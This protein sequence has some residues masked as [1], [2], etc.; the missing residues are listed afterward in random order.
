MEDI[1]M[2]GILRTAGTLWIAGVLLGASGC[3]SHATP[4]PADSAQAQAAL[5][6]ALESWKAGETPENL[7]KQSPP[8]HVKDVDWVGGFRLVDFKADA[9]GKLV[10]YE[11]NY[12]VVLELKSPKG[13][14]VKKKAVYTVTTRPDVFISRQEG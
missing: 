2:A 7:E 11:M 9:E 5:R 10:G 13:A 4:Q 12:T 14:S 6:A 3:G 8:I 1:P